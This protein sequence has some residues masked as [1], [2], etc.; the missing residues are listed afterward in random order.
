MSNLTM[1]SG[2][3]ASGKTTT[4]REMV[5]S[6]GNS[7]RINRDDLRQMMFNGKWTA[8]RED[9][10]I[11]VEKA[12]AEVLA[13]ED[14]NP[15]ID[16][17]NFGKNET[18][19]REFSK[20]KGFSFHK[21]AIDTTLAECIARDL[22]RLNP[23]GRAVVENFARKAGLIQWDDRPIAIVDLD[24]TLAD[25]TH[26]LHHLA[27]EPKDWDSYFAKSGD[28]KPIWS[29]G[30]WVREL[31]KD[32]CIVVVSG[33]PETNQFD[34][35]DWFARHF[36]PGF[37]EHIFMRRGGDKRVDT[38]VKAEIAATL[39][40]NK[41]DLILDDRPSVLR[42]WRELREKHGYVYRVIPVSG[43]CEEF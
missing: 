4:A 27:Q 33:R 2:L 29:V 38:I 3:Q 17:T 5:E 20:E 14:Y 41:V 12:I 37:F 7:G 32:H 9:V 13:K 34:T 22:R 25:G 16:D 43:Q 30:N 31:S 10:V 11:K 39:P 15:I 21:V 23:V 19:W 28:D 40:M 24:G 36:G 8:K 18:M 1:L 6:T 42:M 26:R 35:L